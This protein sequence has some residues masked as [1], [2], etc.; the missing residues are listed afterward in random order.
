MDKVVAKYKKSFNE[1]DEELK[2]NTEFINVFIDDDL[3]VIVDF[4]NELD[5]DNLSIV[6]RVYIDHLISGELYYLVYVHGILVNDAYITLYQILKRLVFENQLLVAPFLLCELFW[7]FGLHEVYD[8]I[9]DRVDYFGDYSIYSKCNAIDNTFDDQTCACFSEVIYNEKVG[10]KIED[11]CD[12]NDQYCKL[13]VENM[14]NQKQCAH[15]ANCNNNIL[16][17]SFQIYQYYNNIINECPNNDFLNCTTNSDS[18]IT[19]DINLDC[20]NCSMNKNCKN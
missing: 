16:S 10:S 7:K 15:F 9:V 17:Q 6:D 20:F 5:F 2:K 12:S 1:I 14:R 19:E 4:L 3:Y 13:I 11:I 8:L 18:A